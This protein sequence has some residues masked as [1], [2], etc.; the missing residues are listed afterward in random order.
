MAPASLASFCGKA[1]NKQ[2]ADV[3]LNE[4]KL[5]AIGRTKADKF[6]LG[7]FCFIYS[8]YGRYIW[9]AIL[10]DIYVSLC[11]LIHVSRILLDT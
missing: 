10:L 1:S 7:S 6:L 11:Y 2:S 8:I 3:R 5:T 9:Q 4:N